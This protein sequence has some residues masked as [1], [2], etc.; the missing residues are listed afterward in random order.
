MQLLKNLLNF[1]SQQEEN[2]RDEKT[3]LLPYEWKKT[4]K[5]AYKYTSHLYVAQRVWYVCQQKSVVEHSEIGWTKEANV[6]MWHIHK[7]KK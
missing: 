3:R 2:K 5:L 1:P 4:E 7:R 6:I